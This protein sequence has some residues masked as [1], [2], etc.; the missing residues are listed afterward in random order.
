[1]DQQIAIATNSL[2]SS[3]SLKANQSEL[4]AVVVS[5]HMKAD[6]EEVA[7]SLSLKADQ[8]ESESALSGVDSRID[9]VDGLLGTKAKQSF[10]DTLET[11][12]SVL[13]DDL[14]SN[15]SRVSVLETDLSDNRGERFGAGPDE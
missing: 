1:M 12:A 6:H 14:T 5:L 2:K 10:L 9:G 3:I 11:R 15:A 7:A 4:D 8:S 13:E